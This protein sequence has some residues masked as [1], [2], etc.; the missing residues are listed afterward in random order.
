MLGIGDQLRILHRI[1]EPLA[2]PAAVSGALAQQI[3]EHAEDLRLAAAVA[4]AQ[5]RM[6]VG[7]G[8]GLPWGKAPVSFA[9]DAGGPRIDAVQVVEYRSDGRVEAVQVEPVHCN[10]ALRL[11]DRIVFVQPVNERAGFLIA[12]H[13]GGKAR[14]SRPFRGWILKMPDVMVQTGDIRPVSFD[15]DESK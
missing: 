6:T 9:G 13:P 8:V 5:R 14:E 12:P 7:G 10:P 2:V 3:P 4:A 1:E 11:P 15:R